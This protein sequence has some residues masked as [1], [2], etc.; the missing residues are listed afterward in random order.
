MIF[1]HRTYII[2]PGKMDATL[3]RFRDHAMRLL[4][5]HGIEVVGFWVTDIGDRSNGELVYLCRFPDLNTR[6]AAW[7]AF[8]AD[9]EWQEARRRSEVDG[10]IVARVDVKVI[11]ATDFSPMK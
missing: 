2:P 10:P 9:P 4:K 3:A 11:A 6:Q 1:E 5:K 8:R 7:A